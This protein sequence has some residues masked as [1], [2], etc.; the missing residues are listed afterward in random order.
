MCARM[1]GTNPRVAQ[2]RDRLAV[3]ALGDITVIEQGACT[4]L[5]TERPVRAGGA[6]DLPEPSHRAGGVF[7]TATARGRLDE[8]GLYPRRDAQLVRVGD[9]LLSGHE[10]LVVA[11]KAVEEHG[12]RPLGV[13]K[14]ESFAALDHLAP[15]GFD[16][17]NGLRLVPA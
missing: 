13:E 7:G 14:P 8:L 3:K 12:A 16:Q 15:C 6:A 2:E 4:R 11:A 5:D 1:R 10:R 17:R 9:G